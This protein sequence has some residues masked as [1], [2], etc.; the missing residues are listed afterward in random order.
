METCKKQNAE[1][2]ACFAV[3][4]AVYNGETYLKKCLDSLINQTLTNIQIICVDDGSTDNSWEIIKHYTT[5]DKRV[6]SIRLN[7][8][9]GAAFARNK[10]IKYVKAAYTTFLDC[11]DTFSIDALE[12]AHQVFRQYRNTDCVLF[13]LK[14][15]DRFQHSVQAYQMKPFVEKTGYTAFVD[16]LTWKIHGVY[17]AKTK[18]FRQFPYDDTCKTYSD[19][20]STRL[21]YL[22]ARKV[23]C[24]DGIYYY[25]QNPKSVTHCI[26]VSRFDYLR[27]NESMKH[28]LKQYNVKD[29]ILTIYENVRWLVL[30]DLYMFHFKYRNQLSA[31]DLAYGMSEIHRVWKNIE[32]KKISKKYKYKFGYM[33]MRISWNLFRIQE[34]LYFRLRVLLKRL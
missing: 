22:H 7:K 11:D 25:L 18:L 8:N 6:M 14:I 17:A 19:D 34:E 30:I 27:A 29:S 16:S 2:I 31:K 4:V 10:A 1:E 20:N 23:R 32:L 15:V 12:K 28:L 21:H 24:C 33:P 9:K 26:Q 13:N 3:L 5:L